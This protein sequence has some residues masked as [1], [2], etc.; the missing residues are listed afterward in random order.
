MGRNRKTRERIPKMFLFLIVSAIII[1]LIVFAVALAGA[2][3]AAFTIVFSDIIVCI[4]I[5]AL[6]GYYLIHRKKN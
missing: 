4:G 3:G 2:F 5:F 1:G 6:I